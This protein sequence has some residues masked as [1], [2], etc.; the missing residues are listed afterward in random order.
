M[1][2]ERKGAGVIIEPTSERLCVHLSPV[3]DEITLSGPTKL[4]PAGTVCVDAESE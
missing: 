1:L 2:S 4:E 3:L